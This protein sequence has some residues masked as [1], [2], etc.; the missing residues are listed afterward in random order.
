MKTITGVETRGPRRAPGQTLLKK[1]H[2]PFT[3]EKFSDDLFLEK[4]FI[5]TPNFLMTFLVVD[6]F[7]ENCVPLTTNLS[8]FVSLS[9]SISATRFSFLHNSGPVSQN[10]PQGIIPSDLPLI[11][12][13]SITLPAQSKSVG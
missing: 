1:V 10:R 6:L 4:E 11:G 2:F 8:V 12:P 3:S 13:R 7:Y 5:H 9:L